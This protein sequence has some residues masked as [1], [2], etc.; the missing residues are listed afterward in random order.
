[1][2]Q[3]T[4]FFNRTNYSPNSFLSLKLIALYVYINICICYVYFIYKYMSIYVC[5]SVCLHF[6]PENFIS[7]FLLKSIVE[8]VVLGEHKTLL[9]ISGLGSTIYLFFSP[10]LPTIA[11]HSSVKQKYSLFPTPSLCN[12]ICQSLTHPQWR[13]R[14]LLLKIFKINHPS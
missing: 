5:V 2:I 14:Y 11:L 6:F 13:R 3:R 7:K 1:M 8:F 4:D 12:H 10:P 9:D